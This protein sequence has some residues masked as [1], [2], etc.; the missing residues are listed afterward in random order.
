MLHVVIDR[1]TAYR[2]GIRCN[3]LLP[4]F[5][6]TPMTDKIP[7]D[8]LTM[9]LLHVMCFPNI[10]YLS[11]TQVIGMIPLGRVAKPEGEC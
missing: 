10:T 6:E 7:S 8:I 3:A 11:H 1:C 9:V 5:T 4:G 2:H